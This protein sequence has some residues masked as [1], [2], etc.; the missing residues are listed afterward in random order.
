MAEK[1]NTVPT[2]SDE[3]IARAQDFWT[4][5]QKQITIVLA[6]I[7][8]GVG[9]WWGYRNFVVKPKAEKAIDAMFKAEEYYRMDSLQKALNGDGINW[10]FVRVIKEYGG[11]ET[12]NLAHLYAGDCYL[13]TGDFN[14]AVKHLKEYSGS[15]KQLQARAYK[16]LGDAYSE[17]G[18]NDDALSNYKKAAGYY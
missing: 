12:G 11:T 16:L 17:L 2:D 5:Y 15:A 8:L 4:K 18:K 13:R 9:G 10:G 1:K 3:I 7:V 14:N 6:V